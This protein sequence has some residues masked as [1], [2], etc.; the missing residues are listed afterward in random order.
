MKSLYSILFALWG[1]A[2]L[3]DPSF[4]KHEW[5]NTDF[6][7]TSIENWVEI[8]SGGPGRD[9]IPAL[10]D[11]EFEPVGAKR[12]WRTRGCDRAGDTGRGARLSAALS[13][14]ARNCE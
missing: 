11:P 1:V 14:V 2:A 3:A 6:S 5:P 12:A 4:W 7:V 10:I 9:G 13:H 8:M